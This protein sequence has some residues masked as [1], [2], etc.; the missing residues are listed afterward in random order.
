ME[1][2]NAEDVARIIG[3]QINKAYLI[4]RSLNE[5]LIKNGVPKACIVAGRVSKKLFHETLKI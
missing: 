5:N 2:Y 1:T 4:I 3:C